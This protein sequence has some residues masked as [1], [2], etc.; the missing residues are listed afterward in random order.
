MSAGINTSLDWLQKLFPNDDLMLG[1]PVQ[2]V[3]DAI[4]DDDD[5]VDDDDNCT[6][7]FYCFK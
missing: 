3:R 7:C 6:Y 4:C 2:N 1:I 5:D